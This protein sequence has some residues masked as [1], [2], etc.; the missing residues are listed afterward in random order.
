MYIKG[1]LIASRLS[2]KWKSG[3]WETLYQTMLEVIDKDTNKLIVNGIDIPNL[4][5]GFSQRES[6]LLAAL[7]VKVSNSISETKLNLFA[8]DTRVEKTANYLTSCN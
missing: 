1:L 5:I 2:K 8:G 7:I 3:T 4:P 6:E